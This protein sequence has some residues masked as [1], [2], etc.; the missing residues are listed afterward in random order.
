MLDLAPKVPRARPVY[1]QP[2]LYVRLMSVVLAPLFILSNS[3]PS[4]AAVPAA[5]TAADIGAPAIRGSAQDAAC[6]AAT[7]C[8]VFAINAAGLGVAG[9]ADQFMFVHQKLTGDGVIKLRLISLVGAPKGEAGLMV[10]E[11]PAATARHVAILAS[12]TGVTVRSRVAASGATGAL[13]ASRAAWLRLERVG[14]VVTS[15]TSNDG[16][17]W[18]VVSVQTLTLPA[19]VYVGIAVT[20]RATNA[21]ATAL[22][23]GMAVTATTPTMPEG[24]SSA[25]VGVAPSPGTAS[26]SGGSFL[27]ASHGGGLGAA[28]DGFRFV[29]ARIR[30]DAKLTTRVVESQGPAGRQA[31]I[32]LRTALDADAAETALLADD[33]GVVFVR[34]ST[35]GQP[36]SKTR[37]ATTVAPV[38]LRLD[39]VG[40]L[41]TA[42]YSTDGSTW[43]TATA[44]AVPLGAD[45]YAGLATSSGPGGGPAAAAFDRLSL[46]SV[47]ANAPPV[48]SL[49]APG[50]GQTFQKGKP[51]AMTA[52]ASDPDDLVARVDFRVNGVKVASDTAAP[53]SATWTSSATGVYS[54]VAEAADFD[55]AVTTSS[56]AV[57]VVA[58][59]APPPGGGGPPAP[60]KPPPPAPGGGN[61]PSP[62]GPWRLEFGAS[63]D[64]HSIDYYR[65]DVSLLGGLLPVLS[66][67]IGKPPVDAAG[68]CRFDVHSWITALPIG[69]YT[70]VVRAV[71]SSGTASSSP[72]SFTR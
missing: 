8:P 62:S 10:R 36:A 26:Y 64:H 12:A 9:T 37:V 49:T 68:N 66:K 32:V 56:A 4:H 3:E 21:M 39:R 71:D 31:G 55:G 54:I 27:A 22:V 69:L 67:N 38:H 50:F 35:A 60:P 58:A 30:G 61:P 14:S 17:Q 18:T 70:V 46:I 20:S 29:Y 25:D 42:S 65:M 41:V 53:Y 33:T 1:K 2:H 72:Y 45:L 16:N 57:I 43:K 13:A 24:W 52:T 28:S 51:V 47:A 44:V 48:V 5:W 7:G 23:A 63:T 15:S 34:R 59:E 6:T 40:L 11:S 19:T